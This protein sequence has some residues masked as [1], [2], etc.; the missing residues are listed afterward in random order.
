MARALRAGGDFVLVSCRDPGVRLPLVQRFR[1]RPQVCSTCPGPEDLLPHC[2]SDG[3]PGLTFRRVL[4]KVFMKTVWWVLL[5]RLWRKCGGKAR[6][7]PARTLSSTTSRQ[8]Q[9]DSC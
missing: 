5:L 8:K 4:M 3:K 7:H 1:F 6:E 2:V 9:L